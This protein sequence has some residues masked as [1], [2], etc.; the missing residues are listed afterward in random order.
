MRM[1]P[2]RVCLSRWVFSEPVRLVLPF[3]FSLSLPTE[4]LTQNV[5][6]M[7]AQLPKADFNTHIL[8]LLIEFLSSDQPPEVRASALQSLPHLQKACVIFIFL[9]FLLF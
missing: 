3:S 2:S 9:F 1:L 4:A 8:P 6:Q 7:S 5:I